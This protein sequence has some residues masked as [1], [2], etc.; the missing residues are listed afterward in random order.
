MPLAAGA[1]DHARERLL[2]LRD[3]VRR[4]DDISEAASY[5]SS[6]R[7]NDGPPLL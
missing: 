4:A 3:I 2:L 5:H 6:A 7:G 1:L